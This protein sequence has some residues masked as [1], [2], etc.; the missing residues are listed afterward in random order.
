MDSGFEAVRK[1]S[2]CSEKDIENFLRVLENSDH[3]G[4]SRLRER[5]MKARL[6][7]FHY[8]NDALVG[9]LALKQPSRSYKKKIFEMAGA[10]YDSS[11]FSVEIGWAFTLPEYR[12]RG[13]FSSLHKKIISGA[14][15]INIYTTIR[16]T[17]TLLQAFL[18]KN[19]FRKTGSPYRGFFGDYSLQLYTLTR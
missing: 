9:V 13:I 5:V 6:L 18:E 19:G 14:G 2:E 3:I 17:N 8:E 10:P 4:K 12:G 1:P 7:A 15:N 16:T 11:K